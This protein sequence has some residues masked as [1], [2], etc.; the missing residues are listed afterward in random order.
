MLLSK[1]QKKSI[2]LSR[3]IWVWF[4]GQRF[5]ATIAFRRGVGRVLVAVVAGDDIIYI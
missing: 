3:Q 5:H 4:D 1:A 2:T